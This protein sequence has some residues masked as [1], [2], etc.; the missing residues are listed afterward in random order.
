[1]HFLLKRHASLRYGSSKFCDVQKVS[2]PTSAAE[3][4]FT[5]QRPRNVIGLYS[6]KA[7][8]PGW[9]VAGKHRRR[10]CFEDGFAIP[11]QH[12]T[13]WRVRPLIAATLLRICSQPCKPIGV[14]TSCPIRVAFVLLLPEGSE[15][16][17][18]IVV[19][20][21]SVSVR[22]G[23]EQLT[24]LSLPKDSDRKLAETCTSDNIVR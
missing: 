11:R 18:Q 7:A 24:A 6:E 4:R 9:S 14:F 3:R 23:I 10:A 13:R 5:K 2:V 15:Y 22:Y 21:C 17:S 12:D 20:L 1:M 19:S 16:S 8:V